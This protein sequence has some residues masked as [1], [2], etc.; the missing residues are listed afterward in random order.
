M[1]PPSVRPR[2]GKRPFRATKS[3]VWKRFPPI[4]PRKPT[5]MTA[6]PP[7]RFQNGS[8]VVRTWEYF[9]DIYS[10]DRA[11]AAHNRTA[12]G[13]DTWHETGA[14]QWA[15][16]RPQRI[17]NRGPASRRPKREGCDLIARRLVVRERWD[18][19]ATRHWIPFPK[20]T[21]GGNRCRPFFLCVH[22]VGGKLGPPPPPGGGEGEEE[23]EEE[24]QL[25]TVDWLT[26]EQLHGSIVII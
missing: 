20:R 11:R 16:L 8:F 13:G 2:L 24:W 25:A 12:R 17:R 3:R 5:D 26:L 9:N 1:E 4:G 23:L 21:D 18:L 6:C 14:S 19:T 22:T 15:W 7:K 10:Y